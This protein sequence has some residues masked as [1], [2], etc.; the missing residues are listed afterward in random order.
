V[1]HR[2]GPADNL[3]CLGASAV[4]PLGVHASHLLRLDHQLVNGRPWQSAAWQLLKQARSHK[5]AVGD[6]RALS[7]DACRRSACTTKQANVH[8]PCCRSQLLT[9]EHLSK[10]SRPAPC[11]TATNCH[12]H[13]SGCVFWITAR[14][15]TRPIMEPL[16]SVWSPK[17]LHLWLDCVRQ[18]L[19][20]VAWRLEFQF[21]SA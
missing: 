2:L 3:Q 9:L 19:R 18:D 4:M 15:V 21:G 11:V 12:S 20:A 14:Y 16:T 13:A 10:G 6:E 17:S 8:L 5:A 1:R 7:L